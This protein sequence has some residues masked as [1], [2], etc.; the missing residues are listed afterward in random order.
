MAM[1]KPV[2]STKLPGVMREF[3]DGNGMVFVDRP[4]DVVIRATELIASGKYK[5]LGTK[6]RQFVER[7]N[8]VS[9]TDEFEKTLQEVIKK[10]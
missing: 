2:I 8:W 5:E 4:E 9:I 6:A 10:K 7:N 1:K 3:G